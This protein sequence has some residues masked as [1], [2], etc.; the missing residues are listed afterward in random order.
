[1]AERVVH[2][3]HKPEDAETAASAIEIVR[4]WVIDQHLQCALSTDVFKEHAQW[5][6]FLADLANHI[7]SG[8]NKMQG[9]DQAETLATVLKVFRNH[10]ADHEAMK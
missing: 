10:F 3:L 8:L 5:G 7:A 1:M 2:E 9:V 4:A 6:V